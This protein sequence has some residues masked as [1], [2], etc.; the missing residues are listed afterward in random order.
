LFVS[1]DPRATGPE[2]KAALRQAFAHASSVGPAAE[3][4]DWMETT[5]PKRW[6]IDGRAR[7]YDWYGAE[8]ASPFL[9]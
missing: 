7:E 5:T 1:A 2:Q 8:G 6:R 9:R 4:L 3:P